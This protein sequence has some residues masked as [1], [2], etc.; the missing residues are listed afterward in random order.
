MDIRLIISFLIICSNIFAQ[1]ETDTIEVPDLILPGIYTNEIDTVKHIVDTTKIYEFA[2]VHQKPKFPNGQQEMLKFIV[3]NI[4][5][6]Q[7]EFN[8]CTKVYVQF[9]IE[10]N[11]EISKPRIIKG[12]N[13][14]LD[15]E[16]MNVVKKLPKWIPGKIHNTSVRV[17]YT[18][19]INFEY[20]K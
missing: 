20:R 14:I 18:L 11:G 1:S 15:R 9:T 13:N 16:A 17:K 8:G 7:S 12:C 5:I 19:P 10:R 3:N 4:N 2:L 6:K